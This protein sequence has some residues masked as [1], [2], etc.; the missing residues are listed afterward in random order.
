M[1]CMLYT[2][3][4]LRT[5]RPTISFHTLPNLRVTHLVLEERVVEVALKPPVEGDRGIHPVDRVGE[6]EVSAVGHED[7]IVRGQVDLDDLSERGA[8]GV[9]E[10]D[11]RSL[12]SI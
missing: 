3:M 1:I 11:F 9:C 7:R 10:I 5:P 2:S 8:R 12:E 4:I 6:G